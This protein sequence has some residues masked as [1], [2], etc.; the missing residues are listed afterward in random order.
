MTE[1]RIHSIDQK[2][3]YAPR[4]VLEVKNLSKNFQVNGISIPVLEGITFDAAHGELIC[5]L[6]RSGYGKSTLL[7][8]LAGFIPPTSGD[9]LLEGEQI[10]GP[11]ADRCVVFQ[12]DALFPW[13]TV[14]ENVAFGLKSKKMNESAI[15]KE[16]G[17]FLSLVGLNGFRGYLPREISGGMKQRVALARVLILK[18]KVLLMDEPFGALDCQTRE[19]MQ[20]L[21]LHLWKQLSITIVFVTHDA[22]EALVLA[23]KVLLMGAN[24]G[25]IERE[26]LVEI[27]RPRAK[28]DKAFLSMMRQLRPGNGLRQV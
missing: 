12:E 28:E 8:I 25:R 14:E 24:T 4:L 2:R 17:H 27:N 13:L 9:V 19:E 11:G 3:Y 7:K 10:M 21:L 16:V 20:G 18:P 5:L 15:A 1:P 22:A 26:L 6:G 23:Y